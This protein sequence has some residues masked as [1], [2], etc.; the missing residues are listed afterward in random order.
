MTPLALPAPG[1]RRLK[2]F[3]GFSETQKMAFLLLV[4]VPAARRAVGRC[5]DPA[6]G[7]SASIPNVPVSPE[8]RA[9]VNPSFKGGGGTRELDNKQ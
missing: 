7:P 6:S 1:V 8:S 3:G 5:S 9:A 2:R 4:I